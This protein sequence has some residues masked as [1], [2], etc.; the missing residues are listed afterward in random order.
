MELVSEITKHKRS[1]HF[2]AYC[3]SYILVGQLVTFLGP[4][5]PYLAEHQ[6]KV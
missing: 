6:N 4:F 1:L 5:I 2:L 3:V